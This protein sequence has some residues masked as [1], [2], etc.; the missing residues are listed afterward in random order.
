[1]NSGAGNQHPASS[2]L[3]L[4]KISQTRLFD[5]LDNSVALS[6]FP[7]ITFY[8]FILPLFGGLLISASNMCCTFMKNYLLV[9][10]SHLPSDKVT[11]GGLEP[12]TD[13]VLRQEP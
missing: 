4:T 5:V 2:F 7:C 10:E 3:D 9:T 6:Q 12:V 8:H 13:G 1:M 11:R